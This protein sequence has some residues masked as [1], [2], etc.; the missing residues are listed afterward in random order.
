MNINFKI[1][2]ACL[3]ILLTSGAKSNA[4]NAVRTATDANGKVRITLPLLS[5][6]PE[7]SR[8]DPLLTQLRFGGMLNGELVGLEMHVPVAS[9]WNGIRSSVESTKIDSWAGPI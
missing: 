5:L 1:C 8:H 3:V 9:E 4:V 6:A 7:K 2:T